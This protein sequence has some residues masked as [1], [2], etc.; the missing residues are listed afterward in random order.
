MEEWISL[1]LQEKSSSTTQEPPVSDENVLIVEKDVG[2]V[3]DQ[4]NSYVK[5]QL[6]QHL[7]TVDE[8]IKPKKQYAHPSLF[9]VANQ[10]SKVL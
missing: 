1:H 4:L 2:R 9:V 10:L 6:R 7:Q 3:A 8:E 5:E